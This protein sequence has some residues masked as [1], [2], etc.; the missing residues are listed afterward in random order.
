MRQGGSW[1][2]LRAL[3]VSSALNRQY[4][5]DLHNGPRLDCPANDT[6]LVGWPRECTADRVSPIW[7]H[8]VVAIPPLAC[9][10]PTAKRDLAE[11]DLTVSL[12]LGLPIQPIDYRVEPR[13]LL[14]NHAPVVHISSRAAP[15]ETCNFV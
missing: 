4:I 14:S 13:N 3:P 11:E 12:V 1:I 7:V 8:A 9:A 15:R 6:L 5:G 2:L 10:P